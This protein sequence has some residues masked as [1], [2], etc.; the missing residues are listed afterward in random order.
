MVF[1]QTCDLTTG[2]GGVMH[3]HLLQTGRKDE[4]VSLVPTAPIRVN[5]KVLT[6]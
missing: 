2:L 1:E 5:P 3:G 6:S 4:P